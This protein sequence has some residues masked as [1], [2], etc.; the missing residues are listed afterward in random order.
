MELRTATHTETGK[1]MVEAWQ[2]GKFMA[3]FCVHEDGVRIVSEHLD[4]VE[5]AATFP[6]SVVIRFS[7]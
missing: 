2:D 4:G 5:H 1:P 3:S 6:P 7:K